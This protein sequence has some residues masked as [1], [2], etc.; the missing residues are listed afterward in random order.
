MAKKPDLLGTCAL[1]GCVGRF[2][3]SHLIPRALTLLTRSG[4]KI[5]EA[6]IGLG[7]MRRPSSWYDNGLV[8]QEGEDI[9]C[10]IDTD[11]I[12]L[13]RGHRLVW[14]WSPQGDPVDPGDVVRTPG[15]IPHRLVAIPRHDAIRLFFLSLLWRAAA[16]TRP[17][18]E[19]V[20]LPANEL[21]DLRI[22]VL[23]K[24]PGAA[25]DYPIQ[26]FQLITRGPPHNRAP[27]MERKR[28]PNMDL[29][30]GAEATYIR[31]YF[32][33]LVAHIY[34]PRQG[35]S[36]AF[37]ETC[38]GVKDESIIFAHTFEESR[39]NANIREMFVT[40]Q[41]ELRTPP[42]AL[43][44]TA[45]AARLASRPSR[46]ESPA[47]AQRGPTRLPSVDRAGFPTVLGPKRH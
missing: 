27:L 13:L 33:G 1:T 34:L 24:Q 19:N 37:V 31:F 46:S 32:D 21:E 38:I 15:L 35:L 25:G 22:R 10:D 18:F 44:C 14:S 2:V 5:V 36:P 43:T 47:L 8:T 12:D 41:L 39:T 40:V 11:G 42:V 3:D 30:W 4:E 6:G 45:E 26:L 28:I 9:L 20:W 16:T 7:V 29:T 23:T 17:E